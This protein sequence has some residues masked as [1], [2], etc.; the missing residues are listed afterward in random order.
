[1]FYGWRVVAGSFV[2]M[3]LVLGFFTY[4][5]T[6]FVTPLREE[7]GVGLEPVMY[8]LTLGTLLGLLVSPLSGILIDRLSVRALMTAGCLL[9]ALGFW[10]MSHATSIGMFNLIFALTFSIGNGIAGTM[11]GSAV[12]SRWFIRSRGR[13]MGITTI[14]TSVGGMTLPALASW[15]M[16]ESGWR[17]T[18]ENFALV[19]AFIVTPWIWLNIRDRPADL[20]LRPDGAAE[21]PDLPAAV[22][23]ASAPGMA[24][25][26]RRREFWLI[27]LSV[28]FLIAAFSATLANLSPYAVEL[29][30]S[31]AKASMLITLLAITGLI[32]KLIFGAAADRFSL[33]WGL[34]ASQALVGIALL[35]MVIQPPFAVVAAAAMCLG[36]AT[37][38]LLP[39][40]NSMMAL[41]FGVDSFGRA[42]GIMGPLI[43][44]FV[45]PAYVLV[46]RLHD[47]QG[48]YTGSLLVFLVLIVL[49]ILLL[50][51]VT[52]PDGEA[53]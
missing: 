52:L 20:G 4:T 5:F 51:P 30:A 11:P 39:V 46:G 9:V 18:L 34:W 37:G 29:G 41:V 25:I 45:M 50:A 35:L 28:G 13:A 38:G 40:W 8:S 48:N 22:P 32:G 6:L 31:K 2:A 24:A 23:P 15:W 1:M 21:D 49:A 26:V 53:G 43:T 17:G 27:G 16:A 7:F 44:L 33:K 36:F 14:G 3:M 42:M 12:V 19:A 10:A 47:L